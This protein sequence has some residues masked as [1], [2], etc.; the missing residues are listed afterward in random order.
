MSDF[1][2]VWDTLLHTVAAELEGRMRDTS[3]VTEDAGDTL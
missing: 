2:E 3:H 1:L